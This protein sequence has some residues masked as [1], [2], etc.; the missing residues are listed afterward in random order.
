ME[1]GHVKAHFVPV[2]RPTYGS[3]TTLY[4]VVKSDA[5]LESQ[6]S[7]NLIRANGLTETC[8]ILQ[9]AAHGAA[10]HNVYLPF[11]FIVF[12]RYLESHPV[13]LP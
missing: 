8:Q 7:S 10:R 6:G 1:T 11:F 4:L 12:T 13:H 9:M 2:T 3:V 5:A